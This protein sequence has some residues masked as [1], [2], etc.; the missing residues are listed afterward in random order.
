MYMVMLFKNSFLESNG[1][2]MIRSFILVV[3]IPASV[4]GEET[5][6]N[7]FRESCLKCHGPEKQKGSLRLD[8]RIT[9]LRGGD[10]GIA[11]DLKNPQ[12]SLLLQ[13]VKSADPNERMPPEGERLKKEQIAM[14]EKWIQDQA[15]FPGSE[16][17]NPST[18]HWAYQPLK[19]PDIPAGNS[20]SPIDRFIEKR[21][22][23]EGLKQNPLADRRTLLRRLKFDLIGLP[24]TPEE[25][26][27]FLND[28]SLNA[29]ERRIDQF[30]AS[31]QYG[32]RWARHWLDVVRFA[33]SNGFEM[34]QP[35]PNA[36]PYRDYV[37]QSF[38]ADKPY[39]RFVQEQLVGDQLNADAGTGFLVGG[40][41]DQVKSPDPSLTL[42]QRADELN[43][44]VST[45]GSA[46]LGLT[47]GCA[48]CHHHKF[49]PISQ[50]DYYQFAAF[51]SGVQ[52][53]ERTLLKSQKDAEAKKAALQIEREQLQNKL[54]DLEPL[55][56]VGSKSVRRLPV[57]ST[58][59][60]D[61]FEPIIAKKIRFTILATN[62]AE[63]CIDEF[64]VFGPD[65]KQKNLAAATNG[66]EI[67]SSGNYSGA[68][69]IHRLEFAHDGKFGNGRSWISNT[70]GKGW[71]ELTFPQAT[72]V[73]RVIWQRDRER[74]YQDRLAIA[75]QIEVSPDGSSWKVVAD[76]QDRVK[77]GTR[78]GL[79][80]EASD[81]NHVERQRLQQQLNQIESELLAIN[82]SKLV[83]AGRFGIN[84]PIH[85]LHRGDPLQPRE[86]VAPASLSSFPQPASLT[87]TSLDSERRLTLAKWLTAPTNPLTVRVIVNRLWQHHFGVGIVDTPS[88]FGLNGGKPTHPEL[89][90]FL[91]SQLIKSD[92]SLKSLHRQILLS[93][94][95]QQSSK[96]TSQGLNKDAQCRLLWRFPPR[97]LDAEPLRDSILFVSGNLDSRM[98]GPGFDFFEPNNNYVRV[99]QPREEFGP[100]EWRR[101]IYAT[102][103]RM[104]LDGIFG[105]FDCPD[106]GQIAPK[107]NQS[108]TPL[109]AL[110]L[111]NSRFMQQQATILAI[112][113]QTESR[114]EITSQAETAFQLVL[115]RSPSSTEKA[116]SIAMIQ[117]HGL[118][119][120]AR[121]LLNSNE[122]LF[123]D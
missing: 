80:N 105:S 78:E 10:T 119:A 13:R 56:Q 36:W 19:T 99:F 43:D 120:F 113:I 41:W 25:M 23:V 116:A 79:S 16:T 115:Q 75:Y 12:Q 20:A 34:N 5:A 27:A 122:F 100:T 117:E 92:W 90:D 49:D 96:A 71:I 73:D 87:A 30:L 33:E 22:E 103:P 65:Q 48:R 102:K 94:T 63:P 91:A 97:R 38:N 24:P 88:D 108:T 9:L 52:H 45:T 69:Q 101:M 18:S 83:Y 64:E 82:Q 11:I 51:L 40:P 31:P 44:M 93:Q 81:P 76:H 7:I 86:M 3:M 67:T 39:D 46:F 123:I 32:E 111:F 61:R 42:Q 21:L 57:N 72:H 35:R 1:H 107:R 68:P 6:L 110:N 37:I 26:I 84:E 4:L 109:Q 95:Y 66:V 114:A 15:P 106:G 98:E 14:I 47:I 89:L 62:Q 74:K 70:P 2:V 50:P 54:I 121:A 58:R 17:R 118:Q 8:D 29:Y 112:R 77:F 28:P 60:V 59:N 55:A 104:Q 53:G 85:R